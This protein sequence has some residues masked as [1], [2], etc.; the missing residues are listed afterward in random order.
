MLGCKFLQSWVVHYSRSYAGLA[1]GLNDATT[2]MLLTDNTK[3]ITWQD[4]N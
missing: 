2:T 1:H 4:K 3:S